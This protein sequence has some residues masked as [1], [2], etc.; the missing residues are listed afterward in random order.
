W[1]PTS[2]TSTSVIVPAPTSTSTATS[3]GSG[4]G[5]CNTGSVQCCNSVV[6][7]DSAHSLLGLLGIVLENV[8]ELVGIGCQGIVGGSTCTSAPVCCENNTFDGLIN[9]GCSPIIINL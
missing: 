5:Q 9:L 1:T 6:S 8:G 4:A 7:G 3:G 2:A